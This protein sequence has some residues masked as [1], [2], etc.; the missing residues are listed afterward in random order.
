MQASI[1]S[2]M[3]TLMFRARLFRARS[4]DQAARTPCGR[5]LA[6]RRDREGDHHQRPACD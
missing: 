5:A 3:P 2:H 4:A 6:G 1:V